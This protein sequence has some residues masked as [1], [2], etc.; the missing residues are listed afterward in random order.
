MRSIAVGVLM[1][2]VCVTAGGA[3]PGSAQEKGRRPVGEIVNPSAEL[4]TPDGRPAQWVMEPRPPA[5]AT[6]GARVASDTAHAGARSLAVTEARVVWTNQTL[7]R[8]YA[9]YNP[10]GWIKTKEVPN[11]AE[12]AP[13]RGAAEVPACG[14]DQAACVANGRRLGCSI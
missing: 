13:P 4:L 14:R 5:G 12:R 2:G 8:P 6:P 10:R 7:V 11:G 3:I 9:S 1:A